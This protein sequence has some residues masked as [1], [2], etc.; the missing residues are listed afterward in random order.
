MFKCNYYEFLRI[1]IENLC[2][3]VVNAFFGIWYCFLLI[4]NQNFSLYLRINCSK[5]LLLKFELDI[6][7]EEWNTLEISALLHT[8]TTEKVR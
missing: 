1:F 2:F 3:Y 6:E 7:L 5:E 8:L 4:Y